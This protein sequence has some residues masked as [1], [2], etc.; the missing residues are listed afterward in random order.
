LAVPPNPENPVV[1]VLLLLFPKAVVLLLPKPP[2]ELPKPVLVLLAV[3][4]NSPPPVFEDVFV[5]PKRLVPVV[6]LPKRPPLDELPPNPVVKLL[7]L[8]AALRALP[9]YI[10]P[11]VL[12]PNVLLPPVLVAKGLLVVLVEP[13]PPVLLVD[14]KAPGGY[15]SAAVRGERDEYSLGVLLLLLFPKPLKPVP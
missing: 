12:D 4:P 13:N 15:A 11:P 3:L 6:L 5:E 1:E 7:A 10:P 2:V 8:V 14:P 9:G